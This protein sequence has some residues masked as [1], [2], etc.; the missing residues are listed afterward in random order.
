MPNDLL[1]NLLAAAAYATFGVLFFLVAFLLVDRITPAE[2]WKEI[3]DEHNTALAILMGA[4]AI[5]ISIVIAAA[6]F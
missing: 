3:I 1:P 6:I 5:A 2:I 4:F